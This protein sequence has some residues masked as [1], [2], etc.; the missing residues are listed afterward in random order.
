VASTAA[1]GTAARTRLENEKR[2]VLL[3][4]LNA[5]E[6]GRR[7]RMKSDFTES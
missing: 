7:K 2:I 6:L 1:N 5:L 3:P 4:T